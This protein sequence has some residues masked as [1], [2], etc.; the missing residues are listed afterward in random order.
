MN[1]LDN[2]Q[3][4]NRYDLVDWI[5]SQVKKRLEADFELL[6]EER[7]RLKKYLKEKVAKIEEERTHLVTLKRLVEQEKEVL[8]RQESALN[9]RSNNLQ[10][11]YDKMNALENK[12]KPFQQIGKFFQDEEVAK[13]VVYEEIPAHSIPINCELFTI[14]ALNVLTKAM[15]LK[16]LGDLVKKTERDFMLEPNL[17]KKS[18]LEIKDALAR[19]GLR[20]AKR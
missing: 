4:T 3:I 20:L 14:R 2:E 11:I 19:H 16:T 8:Q 13:P 6:R 12:L 18:L 17:G 5:T 10:I 9:D 7:E 1:E 15:G